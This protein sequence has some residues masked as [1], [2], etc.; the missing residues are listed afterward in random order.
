MTAQNKQPRVLR[1]RNSQRTRAA[2]LRM[3]AQNKQPRV[4]STAQLAKNAS[5]SAQDDSTKQATAGPSTAQLA[6]NASCS[7]Q[8]DST[9][10]A[11]AGPSTAPPAIRLREAPL[12]MTIL[13]SSIIHAILI[14]SIRPISQQDKAA[15][16]PGIAV[17]GGFVR[18]IWSAH[19]VPEPALRSGSFC[20]D[21]SSSAACAAARR[22]TSRRKGEQ[23]T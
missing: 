21:F 6:K 16:D 22:A 11:T 20:A 13:Y 8:D 1:L 10:Q 14:M 4:L 5:C 23:E 3:T 17:N 19:C 9:K 7:A 2:P 12:R 18:A 15:V